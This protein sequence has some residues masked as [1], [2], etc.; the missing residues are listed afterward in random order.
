MKHASTEHLQALDRSH[1]L[2]PFTDH[3]A[4][5]ARGTR[6][7]TSADGVYLTDSDGK[8]IFDGMSGLWC[9]DVG[10]GRRELAEAAYRQMLELPFYN[11][12]FQ[13]AH[14]PAI[15][16]SERL[17]SISQ[18]HLNRVFF[19]GSGSEAN[20]TVVR[21]VR[22]YWDLMG[23]SGKQTII[24]RKNAYH[25]STVAAAP[26]AGRQFFSRRFRLT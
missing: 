12:F 10:Y 21:M 11:S 7:I 22:R 5:A 18:P 26:A 23:V 14:P 8:R 1:Y 3:K 9:V 16:L 13:T 2:H 20:D 6:V 19:A 24:S 17:A 15:E 4:L 25:G